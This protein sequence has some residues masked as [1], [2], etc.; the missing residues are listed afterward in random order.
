MKFV[1]WG[2]AGKEKP[3]LIDR[4]GRIRDLSGIVD[5]ITPEI[6]NELSAL[7]IIDEKLL[8]LVEGEQRLGSCFSG[9]PNILCIG[10]NYRD[11]AKEMGMELPQE[12]V[13]FSKSTSSLSGPFDPIVIP[14]GSTKVDYEIELA[15]I[16]GREAYNVPT[17][18]VATCIAG[19]CIANDVSERDFQRNRQGQFIKG[20]SAPTFCPLGPWFVT[21]DEIEDPQK[22]VLE[23]KLNGKSVQLS[24]T[25]N[26]VF[27]AFEIVSYLSQ[28]MRLL[29]G[30]VI[31]T[32]T[33]A[34]VG[35]GQSPQ[36]FLKSGD[37]VEAS[38]DNLGE[39]KLIVKR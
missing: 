38:I 19:F 39:Q 20:K 24:N 1:R 9:I 6:F 26:M 30:D 13:V 10:L 18:A 2:A 8:P 28:F 37:I 3:G 32:G 17:A 11:H 14:D 7:K 21:I 16:M 34:G 29:P 27:S 23:L 33:P 4:A 15:I 12:P 5:D 36:R 31:L 25:E 22:L 35:M